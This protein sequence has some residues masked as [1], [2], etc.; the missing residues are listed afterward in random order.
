MAATPGF[1]QVAGPIDD[2][3][4]MSTA[5]LHCPARRGMMEAASF[6]PAPLFGEDAMSLILFVALG[7]ASAGDPT[8]PAELANLLNTPTDNLSKGIPPE[9]PLEEAVAL[10]GLRCKVKI[11]IDT[12]AFQ[13]AGVK[14]IGTEKVRLEPMSGIPLELALQLMLD[15]LPMDATFKTKDVKIIVI[16]GPRTFKD[17]SSSSRLSVRLRTLT[18]EY[19][20]GV[21]EMSFLDALETFRARSDL[22]LWVRAK[23]FTQ[24]WDD[25]KKKK[26]K[27]A[28][29]N[30]AS[31]GD[32]LKKLLAQA[33]ATYIVRNEYLL[34]VPAKTKEK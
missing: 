15:T 7:L 25:M 30:K 12:A 16:P 5:L 2:L 1:P 22:P 18:D 14:E 3:A 23:G 6:L 20:E 28:K 8:T 29:T 27:L 11:E 19:K 26:V 34:I 33:G 31:F 21:E 17:Q 4:G 13:K 32:I 24:S 9:T 10:I